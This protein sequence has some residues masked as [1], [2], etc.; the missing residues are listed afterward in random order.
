ML[1]V[2]ERQEEKKS[3]LGAR[4]HLWQKVHIPTNGA[5]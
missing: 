5:Q 3:K 2:L 4:A 1:K